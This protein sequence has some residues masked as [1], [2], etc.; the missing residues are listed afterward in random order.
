MVTF[1]KRLEGGEGV[2]QV[3]EEHCRQRSS[4]YKVLRTEGAWHV[5]GTARRPRGW[6]E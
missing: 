1:E 6:V 2:S 5:R 3:E 4:E